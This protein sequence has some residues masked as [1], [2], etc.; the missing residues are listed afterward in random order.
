MK[1]LTM[2]FV[3]GSFLACTGNVITFTDSVPGSTTSAVAGIG[4]AVVT[5]GPVTTGVGGSSVSAGGA[6][7]AGGSGF[8]LGDASAGDA[9][10]IA[11][12]G[13]PEP[14]I[15]ALANVDAIASSPTDV[16][17]LDASLAVMRQSK[18]TGVNQ[19]LADMSSPGRQIRVDD[20][21]VFWDESASGSNL[22]GMPLDG[23][24][25]AVRLAAG[26]GSWA[27]STDR[28]FYTPGTSAFVG[29]IDA[30]P[31]AG[32]AP[33]AIVPDAFSAYQ[34]MAVDG[35]GVY[36]FDGR[37]ADAG[38]PGFF[39][40]DFTLNAQR[41]FASSRLIRYLLADGTHVIWSDE[42]NYLEPADILWAPPG[43]GT[44]TTV[45]SA[46]PYVLGLA[47][48]ATTAYWM[49]GGPL[50]GTGTFDL[51]A[52]PLAGGPQRTLACNVLSPSLAVGDDAVYLASQFGAIWKI[53]KN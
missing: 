49:T 51:V 3:A 47:A 34:V 36:W 33:T 19:K 17:W 50:A 45:A 20:T 22:Y 10:L 6:G 5:A 48:D 40:F 32:G 14:P 27:L 52:A 37:G 39:K 46:Q 21:R 29:G 1:R 44:A 9:G 15:F 30:V 26:V 23:S 28:V 7:G 2:F 12:S 18:T 35:S 25:G 8:V 16:Y 4:G 11:C 31:K 38:M 42:P 24:A 41:T 43:G 13:D 53:A